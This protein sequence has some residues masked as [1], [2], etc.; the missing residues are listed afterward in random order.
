MNLSSLLIQILPSRVLLYQTHIVNKYFLYS[1]L[2]ARPNGISEPTTHYYYYP[3]S[4]V[5]IV[6]EVC[7]EYVAAGL[8]D[9]ICQ[10]TRRKPEGNR[11]PRRNYNTLST[12][13]I[14][15]HKTGSGPEI[16]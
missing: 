4:E 15:L 8:Q 6:N 7:Y 3:F 16:N 14:T 12:T 11:I 1:Q 13:A 9:E 5:N 2:N 10:L